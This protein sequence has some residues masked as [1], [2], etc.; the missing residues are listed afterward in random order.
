[1]FECG[2]IMTAFAR[3][4][5]LDGIWVEDYNPQHA[6]SYFTPY[7]EVVTQ[8]Y[9]AARAPHTTQFLGSACFCCSAPSSEVSDS[10]RVHC[11]A[12]DCCEPKRW[13]CVNCSPHDKWQCGMRACCTICRQNTPVT[14]I[15]CDR[16]ECGALYHSSCPLLGGVCVICKMGDLEPI[17]AG[18]SESASPV[19][20]D[21]VAELPSADTAPTASC[22]SGGKKRQLDREE[23]TKHNGN[24]C[25]TPGDSDRCVTPVQESESTSESKDDSA[26]NAVPRRTTR[27]RKEVCYATMQKGST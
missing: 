2:Q 19:E 4:R 10:S 1:M 5:T 24:N 9:A 11:D 26:H 15:R 17:A 23:D 7:P 22:V 25:A 27:P 6:E 12:E 16:Q 20:D 3:V 18:V 13:V 14:S 8:F 21:E